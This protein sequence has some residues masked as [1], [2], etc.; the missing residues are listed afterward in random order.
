M[1]KLNL[2]AIIFCLLMAV[3]TS[4][5]NVRPVLT[6]LNLDTKGVQ[7]EP[8]QMGNLVRIEVEKLNIYDVT[9][10]YD[11]AYIIQKNNLNI[12]NCYGKLCLMEIGNVIKTDYILTGS[13][14]LY[15]ETIVLTLRLVNIKLGSIEKTTVV[16]FLNLPLEMQNMA[17]IAIR[18]MFEKPIDEQLY[19]RLTKP[20]NFDNAI[21]NPYKSII[22]LSGPRFGYSL[23]FGENAQ[24]MKDPV[25]TGGFDA[26]PASFLFGY[27]FEKQYLNEG[28]YQALFEFIPMIGGLDQQMFIPSLTFLNGFR[29]TRTGWEVAIG[30]TFSLATYSR[31]G[32][33][34]DTYYMESDLKKLG[35]TDVQVRNTLNAN[36]TVSLGTS[37]I[38]GVGKTIKSG[39]MNIPINVFGTIPTKEG[40]RIGISVGY[41]A[42]NTSM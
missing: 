17:A 8:S 22:N 19:S 20:F 34:G 1:K 2:M 18:K 28:N 21:N 4:A 29:N 30:P 40:W 5:Q 10:R 32:R 9:D 36:G 25:S 16:E 41:N 7:L 14:E 26:Y 35:Y 33:V 13:A 37:L 6:V 27:Q 11:V 42:K 23:I 3:Q 39:K 38:V 15:G 31:M 24:R 12:T